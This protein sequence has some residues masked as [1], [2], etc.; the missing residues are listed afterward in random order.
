MNI[1]I[2]GATLSEMSLLF[3]KTRGQNPELHKKSRVILHG[4]E[5]DVLGTG[6]GMVNMAYELGVYYS[7]FCPDLA[8]NIGIAGS[9]SP[10][11]KLGEVVEVKSNVYSEMGAENGNDFLDLEQMGFSQFN[12]KGKPIFNLLENPGSPIESLI[13]VKGITVN[14]VHGKAD[15]IQKVKQRLDPEVESMEGAAFFHASLRAGVPFHEIRGISNRV[16]PRNRSNWKI[17][18]AIENVQT[19][20]LEYLKTLSE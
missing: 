7:G 10:K 13:Q 11:I 8:I 3:D 19:F 20:L 5:V 18:E 2:V 12:L 9:F 6:I 17:K 14:C 4:H 16:E 15:S 1:L